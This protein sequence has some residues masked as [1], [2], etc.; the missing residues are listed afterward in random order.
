MRTGRAFAIVIGAVLLTGV[1]AGIA[2]AHVPGSGAT[3]T[4]ASGFGSDFGLGIDHVAAGADHLLFLLMLLFPAPLIALEGRWQA[5]G[6]P[7]RSAI[8]IVLVVTAFAIGHSLTLLLAGLGLVEVPTRLIESLIAVS[9]LVSAIH[10]IRPLVPGGEAGIA[11]GFGLCHGLAFAAIIGEMGLSGSALA[12]TLL[13]FNLGIEM[14]QLLVVA[15]MMPSLYILSKTRIYTPFRIGVASF[16][17]VLSVGWLL[18]RTTL[19]PTDPF[20]AISEALVANPFKVVAAVAVLAAATH[21]TPGLRVPGPPQA[22]K[23]RGP[24]R[25]SAR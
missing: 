23:A 15:L 13:G 8:R 5:S 24:L 10:A 16:G 2:T 6:N 17:V 7:G 12:T 18:E 3:A 11:F 19:L 20:A 25:D 4:G 21:Y 14:V 9:I 22:L 1:T